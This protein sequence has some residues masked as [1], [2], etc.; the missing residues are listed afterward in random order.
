MDDTA[1]LT[2]TLLRPR[3]CETDQMG[4]VHHANYL[5]YFE[6]ARVE[7]LRKRGVDFAEWSRRGI[8]VAV[9]EASVQYRSA[10]FFDDHLVIETRL[11]E[12]RSASIRFAYR[13]VRGDTLIA[14]G[15]T[16]L[17]WMNAERKLQRIPSDIRET[18]SQGEHLESP[19]K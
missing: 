15:D 16:R 2:R 13:L 5:I 19:S 14:E 7:W 18:L 11:S 1:S 17:A 8:N 4:I 6:A 10:A 12:L 3:F 9:V